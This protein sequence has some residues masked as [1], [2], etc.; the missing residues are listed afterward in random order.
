[1]VGIQRSDWVERKSLQEDRLCREHWE[2][3]DEVEDGLEMSSV[4][5]G[6]ST[7]VFDV[8]FVGIAV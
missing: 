1:V 4:E 6:V 7:T 8:F 2:F 5:S 3:E